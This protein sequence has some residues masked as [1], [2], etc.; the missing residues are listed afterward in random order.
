MIDSPE[1]IPEQPAPLVLTGNL[2]E[3]IK[4]TE[5]QLNGVT[6]EAGRS[7]EPIRIWT[8]LYL[9]SDDRPFHRIV[10]GLNGHIQHCAAQAGRAVDLTRSHTILLVIHPDNSGDLWLDSAAVSLKILSKRSI[11]A[12]MVLFDTDIADVTA[13]SFPLVGISKKD[14]IVCIF[15]E[16]WRFA[17]FF[18]FNPEG[19]LSIENMERDL[20]T[21]HRR[22]KYRDLYDAVADENVFGRLIEAGWFP[23]VEILGTEFR[24]LADY[25]EAG[26]ERNEIEANYSRLS[27]QSGSRACSRDGWPN[28]ISRAKSDCCDLRSTISHWGIPSLS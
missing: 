14:R 13:M 10:E 4:L 11:G 1:P 5:L 15:R 22:L 24:Q 27:M 6:A 26:F 7:G 9:T 2:G 25:C 17:L 3:P 23:F 16:G 18:D 28:P 12:G 8:R 21:L 19:N 20:G